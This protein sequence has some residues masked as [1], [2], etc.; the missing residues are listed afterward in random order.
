MKFTGLVMAGGRGTRLGRVIDRVIDRETGREVSREIEKPILI[1]NSRPLIDYSLTAIEGARSVGSVYVVTSPHTR[2][3]ERFI[4]RFIEERMEIRER[5]G[6]EER[7]GRREMQ[8]EIQEK[9]IQVIRA[10]GRGYVFDLNYVLEKLGLGKTV[11]IPSDLPLVR[12]E[13]ID[14]VIEEYERLG[15][16]SLQV[17]LPAEVFKDLG[18][19]PTMVKGGYVPA[20]INIVDGKNLNEN[21]EALCITDKIELAMNINTL[22]DLRVLEEVLDANQQ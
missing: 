4:K 12:S 3:T 6:R 19:T 22:E 21:D 16:S 15:R 17:V 13:D 11:V 1:L 10:P 9:H 5:K 18:I 8:R 20:G 14:W 2:E 7:R